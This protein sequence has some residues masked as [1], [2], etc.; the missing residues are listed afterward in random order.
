MI[1]AYVIRIKQMAISLNYDEAQILELFK[2]TLPSRLNWELFSITN[3]RDAVDVGKTVLKKREDK[4]VT[5]RS[6]RHN[7]IQ[8]SRRCSSFQ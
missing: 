4:Q 5:I 1:D 2:Y 6:V 7:S 3:L 8:G